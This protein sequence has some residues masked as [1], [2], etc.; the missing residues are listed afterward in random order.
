M[1][2]NNLLVNFHWNHHTRQSLF[3]SQTKIL[4]YYWCRFDICVIFHERYHF[5]FLKWSVY[6]SLFLCHIWNVKLIAMQVGCW[7]HFGFFLLHA[8]VVFSIIIIIKTPKIPGICTKKFT[9][10]EVILLLIRRVSLVSLFLSPGNGLNISMSWRK[11]EVVH[12]REKH[13]ENKRLSS[14]RM[15]TVMKTSRHE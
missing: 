3:W 8:C 4:I 6:G 1:K 13:R 15:K 5:V 11:E 12:N 7:V 9:L 2:E 10:L 14:K